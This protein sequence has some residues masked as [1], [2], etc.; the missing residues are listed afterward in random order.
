[1]HV[2]PLEWLVRF[3]K[4]IKG[5]GGY[6]IYYV[7]KNNKAYLVLNTATSS[8]CACIDHVNDIPVSFRLY[9]SDTDKFKAYKMSQVTTSCMTV[10]VQGHVHIN[11]TRA[12]E[13][14]LEPTLQEVALPAFEYDIASLVA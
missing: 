7:A 4:S 5:L 2:L 12:S 6:D 9:K 13:D 3:F 1:M 10:N 14:D 8:S 11:D